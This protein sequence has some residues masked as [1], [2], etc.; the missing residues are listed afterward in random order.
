MRVFKRVSANTANTT[1]GFFRWYPLFVLVLSV[2]C[3][4]HRTLSRPGC[5]LEVPV[6]VSVGGVS[7]VSRC[8]ESKGLR[9]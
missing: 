5:G 2:L 3:N 7:D 4:L 9:I 1:A 6:A 8:V